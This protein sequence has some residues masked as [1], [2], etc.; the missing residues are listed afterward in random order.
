MTKV[1]EKI[2]EILKLDA[3][4]KDKELRRAA[5]GLT[6]LV[7]LL[8]AK[9]VVGPDPDAI[10]DLIMNTDINFSP[11]CIER[12]VAIV[13]EIMCWSLESYR[14]TGID[15]DDMIYIPAV[16]HMT[17]S[18]KYGLVVIDELQDLTKSQSM[19][20]LSI[21]DD[22][23]ILAIGDPRQA[24]YAFRGAHGG[25]FYDFKEAGCTE[26]SLPL[27]YRCCKRVTNLAKRMAPE[28]VAFRDVDGE[29][30]IVKEPKDALKGLNP[31]SL[32]VTRTN[33]SC[34][35]ACLELILSN[36]PALVVGRD[37]EESLANLIEKFISKKSV[38]TA[39]DVSHAAIDYA[40]AALVKFESQPQLANAESDKAA[41]ISVIA[42]MTQGAAGN[43]LNTLHNLFNPVSNGGKKPIKVST[44]HR[45]KGLEAK[46]V[47]VLGYNDL[48]EAAIKADQSNYGQDNNLWFVAVTR[49]FDKLVLS[50]SDYKKQRKI[51][52]KKKKD[53][54]AKETGKIN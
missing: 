10:L 28:L 44:I 34:I 54:L 37:F 1:Y 3:D 53:D 25:S 6:R 22:N 27:T 24:I 48:N 36:K 18:Y 31:G 39:T 7:S 17:K 2:C 45:A 8:K 12:A 38:T 42:Q 30:N 52:S 14:S 21:A 51:A 13:D 35:S 23:P 40:E 50:E 47:V 26:L 49:A 41:A 15:M 46:T 16:R 11:L 5:V 19:L 43:V 32:I 29:I 33:L 20:S 9:A 4:K